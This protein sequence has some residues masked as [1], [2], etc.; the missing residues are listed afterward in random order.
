M[1]LAA[2]IVLAET[3]VPSVANAKLN[4]AKNAAGRLSQWSMRV[5][6]FQRTLP[7]RVAPT[8]VTAIPMKPPK[9]KA[10]GITKSWMYCLQVKTLAARNGERKLET[11]A[12]SC[13][14]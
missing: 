13:F 14:A 8:D 12:R 10:T 7:Y 6:G 9:V 1:S 11:H 5:R 4:A 2:E 3:F